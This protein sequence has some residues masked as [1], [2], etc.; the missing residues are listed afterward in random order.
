MSRLKTVISAVDIIGSKHL[1]SHL[2]HGPLLRQS[3]ADRKA[4]HYSEYAVIIAE[5]KLSVPVD[6]VSGIVGLLD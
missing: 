2:G 6:I 3:P 5:V 4:L 1:S